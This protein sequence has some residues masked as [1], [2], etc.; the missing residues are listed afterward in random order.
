MSRTMAR[1]STSATTMLACII[2][3]TRKTV[4]LG[5]AMQPSVAT[6]NSPTPQS[7][8]GRRPQRS[9]SGPI[10]ICSAAFTAR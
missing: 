5:A 2:R 7:T 1:E 10:T 9:E 8:T 4:T 3:N 6:R